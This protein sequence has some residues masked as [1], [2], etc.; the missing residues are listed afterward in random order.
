LG[1]GDE[2]KVE[3]EEELELFVEDDGEEGECIV[4]LISNDIWWV[5]RF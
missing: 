3:V 5:S 4:L 1:E 2:E